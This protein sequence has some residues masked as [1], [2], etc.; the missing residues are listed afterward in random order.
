M[1]CAV[2]VVGDTPSDK[3]EGASSHRQLRERTEMRLKNATP[4]RS[5]LS[6]RSARHANDMAD[7]D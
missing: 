7:L 1:D 5:R 3:P 6:R 2:G 4:A